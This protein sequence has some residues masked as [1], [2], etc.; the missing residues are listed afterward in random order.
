MPSRRKAPTRLT[1][2][3]VAHSE[4]TKR[5]QDRIDLGKTFLDK[6]IRNDDELESAKTDIEKWS[7]Y[8]IELLSRIFDQQSL[9]SEYSDTNSHRAHSLYSDFKERVFEQQDFLEK[10]VQMLE[11][12]VERLP[13][14][15]QLEAT[16]A[17]SNREI[18]TRISE[19]KKKI[20][21]VHGHNEAYREQVAR[22]IS[23]LDL[24]PI[25]LHEQPNRGMTV[26]EK[27]EESA[28]VDF[29]VVILTADD[30]CLDR[31]DKRLARARQNVVFE[32]GY[33]FGRLGR[34]RVAALH[35]PGVEIPSDIHGMVYIKLDADGAWRF[36]LAKELKSSGLNVDLNR[37]AV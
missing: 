27:F 3:L 34:H 35:A 5:L 24:K 21:I 37:A 25:I 13:L 31:N 36:A 30:Y 7:K 16:S 6:R 11:S 12:I 23:S 10:R 4:A 9:A 22:L 19:G 26:I 29:A 14:I 32:L 17:D 15:P 2:L 33:F 28:S 18:P 8:N 1:S 20:F